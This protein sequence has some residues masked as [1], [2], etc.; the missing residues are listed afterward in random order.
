MLFLR[1][2]FPE[3]KNR[4]G[5]KV[6][7]SPST[8]SAPPGWPAR[9]ETVGWCGRGP[10]LSRGPRISFTQN[11]TPGPLISPVFHGGPLTLSPLTLSH[12]RLFTLFTP[13][14]SAPCSTESMP[15]CPPLRGTHHSR[16]NATVFRSS[17]A[18]SKTSKELSSGPRLLSGIFS[19][20]L[21][22]HFIGYILLTFQVSAQD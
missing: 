19:L 3:R 15:C 8:G 20:R 22:P 16:L 4:A 12:P 11:L 1:N 2:P 10:T 17:T 6:L 13:P 14:S 7:Q 5:W 18:R 21:A 9:P